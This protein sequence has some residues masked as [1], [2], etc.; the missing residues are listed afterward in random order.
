MRKRGEK[1][2]YPAENEGKMWDITLKSAIFLDFHL[3]K[4][5]FKLIF[6][7]SR[8]KGGK[9]IYTNPKFKRKKRNK[10]K[11]ILNNIIIH[12]HTYILIFDIITSFINKKKIITL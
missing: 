6:L 10:R 5:D 7:F 12:T 9:K 4:E 11:K 8:S 3:E 1:D 2:G